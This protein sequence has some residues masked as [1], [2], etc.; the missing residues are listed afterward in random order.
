MA[1][2]GKW[3]PVGSDD[4]QS[5]QIGKYQIITQLS[6]GGMAELFLG[7]TA[8]PG[9]FRKY[10]ALKRILP[11]V[12]G[13]EQF[14]R[15][16]LDEARITAAFNHPNIA[17]VFEL[18]EED[19][20]LFLAMEFIA[21][22]NLDQLTAAYRRRQEPIPLEYSVSAVR[23]VCQALHYA[24]TFTDPSGRPSP[25]IHRDV[26][27]KNI[28]VTY[29][30]VVKLL[31][32]GIA[33]ARNSL[34][35]TRAGTVKGTSGY[36]SPEQVRGEKLDGRS[37]VF[38]VG[39]VLW[40]LATGERLFA[41][42]TE[43]DEMVNILEAPIPAPRH[44]SMGMFEGLAA[45]ILRALERDP[46]R[47]F[48][49][50][51]D[52]SRALEQ[53]AGRELWDAD[54]RAAVMRQLFEKKMTATRT[55]LESADASANA[56]AEDIFASLHPK[57]HRTE[58]YEEKVPKAPAPKAPP[59]RSPTLEEDETSNVKLDP[60]LTE[61]DVRVPATRVA[62]Q[63]M[64]DSSPG[65]GKTLNT[66]LWIGVLTSIVLGGGYL[67]L[68]LTKRLN[69]EVQPE[70]VVKTYADPRLKVFPEPGQPV[71]PT[72]DASD[73]GPAAPGVAEAPGAQDGKAAQPGAKESPSTKEG[74]EKPSKGSRTAQGKMT[75]VI[76]PEA[77][78][79]L[80]KRLLGKT[81]LFNTPMPVGTNLLRIVGPDKKQ[82]V[83]SVP[84][85]AG[86]T[87]LHRF[88]LNDIP[89]AH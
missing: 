24:H 82:R 63:T 22:Q 13:N 54:R 38:S 10:V 45:V 41:G 37:D 12:R 84:I 1:A 23:D 16:F 56:A 75:L 14:V 73:A 19:D 58:P 59:R 60:S 3:A 20:G 18:G 70:P 88:S 65:G 80:G 35:R 49:T 67:A 32:F 78:V 5:E 9:G 7:F 81:P 89:E 76:N 42:K 26:A 86:K 85:E 74:A 55:L 66:V 46:E 33:K 68:T 64:R 69:D 4:P 52:L 79:F 36:M 27:Q 57:R 17:Q 39:V 6:V 30:G 43:R 51:K 15:M 87:A 25:I 77:Q 83:L 47:R 71:K 29:D 44:P 31:D 72:S 40:E 61:E 11:D 48:Q 50:A 28:M 8:G 34:E 62:P 2:S 53:T 21:G